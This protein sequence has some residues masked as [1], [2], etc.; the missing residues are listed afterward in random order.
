ML[1]SLDTLFD[2]VVQTASRGGN[3]CAHSTC[4]TQDVA[5]LSKYDRGHDNTEDILRC[6]GPVMSHG[7]CTAPKSPPK[8]KLKSGFTSDTAAAVPML[9]DETVRQHNQPYSMLLIAYT[10]CE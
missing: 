9:P 2:F 5:K 8:S 7:D 1:P 3:S 10:D 6:D 4:K